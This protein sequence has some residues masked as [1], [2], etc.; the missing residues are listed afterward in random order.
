MNLQEE[1]ENRT[2]NLAIST[3]KLTG[4]AVIS[5]FRKYLQHRAKVKAGKVA[6]SH[7]GKMTVDEL[8]GQGQGAQQIDIANSGIRDFERILNTYGVDYA[9]RKDI[10]QDPPRYL[11]FFKAK[12]ADVL[13]SAFKEYSH[14]LNSREKRPSVRKMLQKFKEFAKAAPQKVHEKKQE[15]E[16]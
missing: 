10:T 16:R 13:T 8:V 6:D 1:V 2:V 12:D 9:L 5:A 15:Q 4:R 7:H 3:T 11:V 14:E